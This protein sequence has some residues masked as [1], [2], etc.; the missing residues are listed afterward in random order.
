MALERAPQAERSNPY[1]YDD[2]PSIHDIAEHPEE[3]MPSQRLEWT[4]FGGKRKDIPAFGAQGTDIPASID[5]EPGG[6]I[7][8]HAAANQDAR[9]P[10]GPVAKKPPGK[11]DSPRRGLD[12]PR[13]GGQDEASWPNAPDEEVGRW[14]EGAQR[15]VDQRKYNCHKTPAEEAKEQEEHDLDPTVWAVACVPPKAIRWGREVATG[16]YSVVYSASLW[17]TR[18]AVKVYKTNTL[19][20]E[21]T[22]LIRL[23][24]PNILSMVGSFHFEENDKTWF[25]IV[26]DFYLGSSLCDRIF[27]FKDLTLTPALHICAQVARAV[28]YLHEVGCQHRN[29]K[30]KNVLLKRWDLKNVDARLADFGIAYFVGE[31]SSVTSTCQGTVGYMALEAYHNQH[32]YSTDVYALGAVV[33]ESLLMRGPH[34]AAEVK[35]VYCDQRKIPEADREKTRF[36]QADMT[37]TLRWMAGKV[38]PP[39]ELCEKKVPGSGALLKKCFAPFVGNRPLAGEVVHALV[40]IARVEDE[41]PNFEPRP[42]GRTGEPHGRQHRTPHP[43]PERT[44]RREGSKVT[45][46]EGKGVHFLAAPGAPRCAARTS[47]REKSRTGILPKVQEVWVGS[48]A[49]DNKNWPTKRGGGDAHFASSQGERMRLNERQA[50]AWFNS[51]PPGRVQQP[52]EPLERWHQSAPTA[53]PAPSTTAGSRPAWRIPR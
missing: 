30:S 14:P 19:R 10:D 12:S 26:T 46:R 34:S 21:F 20:S 7:S 18:V 42:S 43:P 38:M 16:A 49:S 3:S 31:E 6:E 23:R 25:A 40:K 8:T 11:C 22:T 37:A 4:G 9:L 39:V 17:G 33:F 15:A 28:A 36:G 48:A 13:R 29:V 24:H 50:V 52:D 35:E 51:A 53:A 45:F 32:Q 1:A 2:P 27:K 44:W 41:A 47:A 5:E